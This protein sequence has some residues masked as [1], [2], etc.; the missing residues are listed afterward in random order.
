MRRPWRRQWFTCFFLEFLCSSY[1]WNRWPLELKKRK[2]GKIIACCDPS[3]KY[4]SNWKPSLNHNLDWNGQHWKVWCFSNTLALY[5]SITWCT[6]GN[7]SLLL[8]S[9]AKIGTSWNLGMPKEWLYHEINIVVAMIFLLVICIVPRLHFKNKQMVHK[10][11]SPNLNCQKHTNKRHLQLKP[12]H[13]S[14]PPIFVQNLLL[15][16]KKN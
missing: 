11:T 14:T 9:C 5:K 6:I 2:S 3:E 4:Q 12:L 8:C 10:Y 1:V 15:P 13:A 16:P 7:M